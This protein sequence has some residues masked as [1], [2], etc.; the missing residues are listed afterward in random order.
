MSTNNK[1]NNN[2][3]EEKRKKKEENIQTGHIKMEEKQAR[4]NDEKVQPQVSERRQQLE[5]SRR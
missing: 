3:S 5:D 1:V 4:Q 2:R